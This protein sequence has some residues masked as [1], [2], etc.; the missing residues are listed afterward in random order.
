[1][2]KKAKAEEKRLRRKQRK[3]EPKAAPAPPEERFASE[4]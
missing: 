2:E 1:M 3:L 4:D